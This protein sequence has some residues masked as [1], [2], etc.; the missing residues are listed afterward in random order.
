MAFFKIYEIL[1]REI[2]TTVTYFNDSVLICH[3]RNGFQFLKSR[4]KYKFR[5]LKMIATELG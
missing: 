1:I 3:K 5:N 4:F 2:I